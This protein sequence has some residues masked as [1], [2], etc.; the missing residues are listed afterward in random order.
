MRYTRETTATNKHNHT[1]RA[2]GDGE[3]LGAV[4]VQEGR[5]EHRLHVPH[6]RRRV[7]VGRGLLRIPAQG[8]HLVTDPHVSVVR[9]VKLNDNDYDNVCVFFV[10]RNRA[11]HNKDRDRRERQGGTTA[12]DKATEGER[13][14]QNNA[15]SEL[16]LQTTTGW[17]KW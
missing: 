15:T 11:P 2:A 9:Q 5:L 17:H 7:Q 10:G 1:H 16:Q 12:N 8:H 14:R 3:R 13:S 4:G 6:V